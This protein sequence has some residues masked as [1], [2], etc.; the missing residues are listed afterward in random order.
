MVV[1]KAGDRVHRHRPGA[2]VLHIDVGEKLRR[3]IIRGSEYTID[4]ASIFLNPFGRQR[5]ELAIIVGQVPYI[6]ALGVAGTHLSSYTVRLIA[7]LCPCFLV[8]KDFIILSCTLGIKFLVLDS[9]L[10]DIRENG[11]IKIELV[12]PGPKTV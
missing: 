2:K 4:C 8:T 6:Q 7:I 9:L 12:L 11:P 1:D 3:E 10:T 5:R